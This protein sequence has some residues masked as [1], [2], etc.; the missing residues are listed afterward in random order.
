L[1]HNLHPLQN[2]IPYKLT[3]TNNEVQCHWLNTFDKKFAEPFFDETIAACKGLLRLNVYRESVSDLDMMVDWSAGFKEVVV[4]TAIIFHVSRCGSTLIS[5]LLGMSEENISLA[6]VPFF[7][8]IL[9]LRYKN[10]NYSEE[11]IDNLLKASLKFYGQDRSGK[12]KHLFIKTDSWHILFYKQLRKLYPDVPFILLYRSPDEVLNSHTKLRGV[13]AVPGL[14]EPE[15]FGFEAEGIS[16]LS[17]N[18]YTVEVLECYLKIYLKVAENDKLN[19]LVNYSEGIM[20]IMNKIASFSNVAISEADLHK[21]QE[22][23]GYHSKHPSKVFSE[24]QPNDVPGFLSKVFELYN[25]VE[26]KRLKG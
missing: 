12:E 22:R 1:N 23:S 16:N 9:R 20:P 17:L 13:Q 26:A 11:D 10:N 4:P 21:M 5:Q 3:Y 14:I 24:E 8:D 7:D 6:E 18:E 25:A 2:W 19:L 15:L